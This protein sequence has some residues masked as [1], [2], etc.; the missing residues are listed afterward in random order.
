MEKI[1]VQGRKLPNEMRTTLAALSGVQYA[2]SGQLLQGN[3]TWIYFLG[4]LRTVDK[5]GDA[6]DRYFQG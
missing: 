3:T 6:A 2:T 4:F 5:A 1:L